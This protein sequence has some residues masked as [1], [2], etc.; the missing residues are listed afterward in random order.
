[1]FFVSHVEILGLE[2]H[3]VTKTHLSSVSL[4]TFY[5]LAS[6]LT[7]CDAVHRYS[8]CVN[9]PKARVPRKH[10]CLWNV[11]AVFVFHCELYDY[12]VTILISSPHQT[13]LNLIYSAIRCKIVYGSEKN[14]DK[15]FIDAHGIIRRREGDGCWLYRLSLSHST[16]C[17]YVGCLPEHPLRVKSGLRIIEVTSGTTHSICFFLFRFLQWLSGKMVLEIPEVS[18]VYCY[19][20]QEATV[21]NVTYLS[22]RYVSILPIF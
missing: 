14:F 6:S 1:M 13:D 7:E 10:W 11:G 8:R 17:F 20:N 18:I 22:E 16:C 9:D 3:I 5:C 21:R 4:F 19:Y 2:K 15:I 12:G